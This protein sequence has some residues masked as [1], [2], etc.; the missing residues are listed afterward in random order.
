MCER[1]VFSTDYLPMNMI[2]VTEHLC[3]FTSA[4]YMSA[5]VCA[6]VLPVGKH[7]YENVFLNVTFHTSACM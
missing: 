6:C 3:M 4:G 7:V 2:K 5:L 1:G